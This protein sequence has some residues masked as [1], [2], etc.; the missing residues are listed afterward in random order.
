M[1]KV[2]RHFTL[3]ARRTLNVAQAAAEQRHSPFVGT[4]HLL[5]GCLQSDFVKQAFAASSVDADALSRIVEKELGAIRDDPLPVKDLSV[6]VKRALERTVDLARKH[7]QQ[8]NS[9]HLVLALLQQPEPFLAAILREFPQLETKIVADF[10]KKQSHQLSNTSESA[11]SESK[12]LAISDFAQ[13]KRKS[14]RQQKADLRNVPPHLRPKTSAKPKPTENPNL[15]IYIGLGLLAA[16]LYGAYVAPSITIAVVIVVGGWIVSLVLH[17]FAH[18]LVAYWGGDHTVVDK[19]YLTLNP[20]KYTHPLLSI[21]LP[22]FFLA[23]GGIGLPGGAVYIERH[24]LRSNIWNSYVSAAGPIATFICMIVFSAPFWLG[25]VTWERYF[26]NQVQW[27]S[28]AFLVWIQAIAIL[29]NL[30]PI[31]PLDGFGIIEPFLPPNWALQ[32]RSF[33]SIGFLV[34]ILM[35][36]LPDSGTGFHPARALFEQA[37]SMA[38][39]L[40]VEGWQV[41][42]GYQAFRFWD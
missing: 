25:Y 7:S 34:I 20:L 36:W 30:L 37:D 11:G 29:L 24:R 42:Q 23:I 19:G 15:P 35:F 17:E 41:S 13:P 8:V 14:K 40:D 6:E 10:V 16:I 38:D 9:G 27:S 39:Q 1:S 5:L 4:E 31:P 2:E 3:D 26:E 33:G 28:L 32:L 22:L 18:A 12:I 21:G